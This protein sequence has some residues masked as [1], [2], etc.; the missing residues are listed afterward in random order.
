MDEKILKERTKQFALHVIRLVEAMPRSQ[1]T[2][3]IGNQLIRS[4]TSVAANYRAACRVRSKPD[5][6]NKMG[7]LVEEPDES[8]FWLELIV[9]ANLMSAERVKDLLQEANELTA[10]FVAS[11]K[12]VKPYFS[13]VKEKS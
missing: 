3:V 7:V 8:H 6:A 2:N 5:F 9:D 4:A 13:S 11:H 10:I 1:A 12:T